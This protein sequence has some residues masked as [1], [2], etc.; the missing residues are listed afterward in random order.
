MKKQLSIL[1]SIVLFISVFSF[2]V[3][4]KSYSQYNKYIK[5]AVLS[6]KSC[7]MKATGFLYDFDKNGTKELV[8]N[9][10]KKSAK[11]G[12]I[13]VAS[14]YTIKGKKVKTL[15]KNKKL[16]TENASG[17]DVGVAIKGKKRYLLLN[18]SVDG[19]CKETTVKLYKISSSKAK[20]SKT[21]NCSLY[22]N[23]DK[24]KAVTKAYISGKKTSYKKYVKWQKSFKLKYLKLYKAPFDTL[25]EYSFISTANA[26]KKL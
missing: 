18:K 7:D 20:C 11:Y 15:M 12:R 9:Y 6:S 25:Y 26:L 16:V 21:G 4:A 22:Y 5:S 2:S 24:K 1:L 19:G 8:I 10:W 17:G 23:Y 3:E 13:K 14:V